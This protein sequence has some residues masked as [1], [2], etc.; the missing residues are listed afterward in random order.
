M[1]LHV[2]LGEKNAEVARTTFPQVLL[3]I[4]SLLIKYDNSLIVCQVK[5]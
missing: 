1:Q 3:L 4:Q 2:L 5:F